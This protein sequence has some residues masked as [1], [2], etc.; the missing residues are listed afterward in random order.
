M[1]QTPL[2]I[3]QYNFY[4]NPSQAY[5]F[6]DKGLLLKSSFWLTRE[7]RIIR[8]DGLQINNVNV[9]LFF[10]I[11]ETKEVHV[12]Q[13]KN[14]NTPKGLLESFAPLRSTIKCQM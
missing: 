10:Q 3:D 11:H 5:T 1:Q 4:Y 7:D 12:Y 13:T 14:Y 2:L 9:V 8:T 6:S